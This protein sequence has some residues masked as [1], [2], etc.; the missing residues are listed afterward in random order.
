MKKG[1]TLIELL[2]VIAIIAIL[3]A[4]LFPV[5]A[6]AR[7]K[8]RQISCLSNEKQLG[9]GFIQYAQD[10][11]ETMP[12]DSNWPY[13]DE[14]GWA[15]EIYPY[16]KSVNVY[17]C[18]DDPNHQNGYNEVS[19]AMNGNLMGAFPGYGIPNKPGSV[20]SGQNGPAD[21]VL[22]FE[23]QG[24]CGIVLTNANEGNSASG[25]GMEDEGNGSTGENGS[26][27]PNGGAPQSGYAGA[28]YATGNIGGYTLQTI[29]TG[30]VHTGGSNYLAADG[31]A[32]WLKGSSVS[33]GY[34]APTAATQQTNPANNSHGTPGTAAGT[35]SMQLWNGG[36][37]A[38]TFSPV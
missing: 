11:D 26:N 13:A 5:F 35:G 19:Y 12:Y 29:S 6:Q 30:A 7:E 25:R 8:A 1:F 3:A 32:K 18:P 34:P 37:V 33:G 10:N 38:L 24:N 20:L 23:V 27:G 31:H 17:T 14:H 28:Y 22:L 9:L 16:V 21:T 2:V 4:I 36:S 15:G